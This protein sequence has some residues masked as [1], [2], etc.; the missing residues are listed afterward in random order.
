[1]RV[2]IR[3]FTFIDGAAYPALSSSSTFLPFLPFSCI[4]PTLK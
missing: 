4:F 2:A 1:M 3:P